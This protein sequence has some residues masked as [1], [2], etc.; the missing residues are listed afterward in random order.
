MAEM[1]FEFDR[2]SIQRIQSDTDMRKAV[3]SIASDVASEI[4]RRA[5][6]MVRSN[7][8]FF[9]ETERSGDGWEGRAAVKSPFWHWAEYGTSGRHFRSPQPYIRPAAQSVM[10]RLGGR[11]KTD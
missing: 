10:S 6:G 1:R 8:R 3:E 4:E 9:A 11:W 7:G 5:P 2:Q